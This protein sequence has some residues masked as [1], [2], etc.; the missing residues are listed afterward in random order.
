MTRWYL[1]STFTNFNWQQDL[2]SQIQ[3]RIK[4]LSILMHES[5][6]QVEKAILFRNYFVSGV[7]NKKAFV[8]RRS[9]VL[10]ASQKIIFSSFLW[11]DNLLRLKYQK[12]LQWSGSFYCISQ[13]FW[14]RAS[15]CKLSTQKVCLLSRYLLVYRFLNFYFV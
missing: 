6:K 11:K 12:Y 7:F 5:F 2:I 9:K 4:T 10:R 13:Y 14:F 15:S 3:E 8:R 1:R